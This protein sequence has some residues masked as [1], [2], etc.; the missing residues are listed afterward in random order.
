MMDPSKGHEFIGY[1]PP[2]PVKPTKGETRSRKAEMEVATGGPSRVN[3]SLTDEGPQTRFICPRVR[4]HQF[5][6]SFSYL[7]LA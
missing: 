3:F 4:T 2:P 1:P 5:L 6:Y 7:A